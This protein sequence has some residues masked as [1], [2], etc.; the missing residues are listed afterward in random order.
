MGGNEKADGG[1]IPSW[2][3]GDDG[4]KEFEKLRLLE[5]E[6]DGA[7]RRWNGTHWWDK[8]VILVSLDGV[9]ADYLEKGLTKHLVGISRK[10]IV[11]FLSLIFYFSLPFP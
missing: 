1:K 7:G 10:G 11:R 8:T 9:R 5:G 2:A 6:G 4:A 3:G